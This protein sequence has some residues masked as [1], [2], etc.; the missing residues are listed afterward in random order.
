MKIAS[1]VCRLDDNP[2][3]FEGHRVVLKSNG[4]LGRLPGHFKGASRVAAYAH[5]RHPTSGS[6][7]LGTTVIWNPTWR[8]R[9][10]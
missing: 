2:K 4:G 7:K 1:D 9:L 6:R 5:A 8:S 3:P 10:V